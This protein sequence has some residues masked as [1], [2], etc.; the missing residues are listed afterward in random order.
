MADSEKNKKIKL[1]FAIVALLVGGV[2][3]AYQFGLINLTPKV[4]PGT[5][6]SGANAPLV[7]TPT[8]TEQEKIEAEAEEAIIKEDA[9]TKPT[10][11]S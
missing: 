4:E 5:A 8:L 6:D 11:G 2:L 7:T 3:M 9:K 1:I 10:S